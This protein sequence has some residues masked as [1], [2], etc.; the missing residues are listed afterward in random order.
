MTCHWSRDYDDIVS[1]MA[2]LDGFICMKFVSTMPFPKALPRLKSR[3]IWLAL[4]QKLGI[5]VSA[6]VQPL[7]FTEVPVDQ[8]LKWLSGAVDGFICMKSVSTMPFPKA[9]PRLKSRLIWLALWQKLGIRVS[10]GVQPLAF[11]RVP[12]A[13]WLKWLK[14]CYLKLSNISTI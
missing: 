13:Q 3:L 12:V 2:T 14:W 11:T 4:W 7:A 1:W 9:L 6:G 8:W 5:R 10:A